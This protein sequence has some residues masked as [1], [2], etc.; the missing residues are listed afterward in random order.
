MKEEIERLSKLLSPAT[1]CVV[2]CGGNDVLGL[3]GLMQSPVSSMIEAAELL[4]SWQ[5]NFL[6]RDVRM[7]VMVLSQH[8][9]TAVATIYDRVPEISAVLRATLTP[10]NDVILRE[11]ANWRLPVV[12][13]CLTCKVASDYS[14]SSPI[15][16]SA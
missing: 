2:S 4:T 9:P 8:L 12:D 14:S 16:P 5:A 13:L 11:A 6:T 7:L 10:F 3:L 1:R 15:E